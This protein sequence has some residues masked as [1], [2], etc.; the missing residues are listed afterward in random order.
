MTR[1][2]L[3]EE[4]R[5]AKGNNLVIAHQHF[6]NS[7]L[8]G[9]DLSFVTFENCI[10]AEI[11]FYKTRSKPSTFMN[12]VFIYCDFKGSKMPMSQWSEYDNCEFDIQYSAAYKNISLLNGKAQVK[13]DPPVENHECI[14][15]LEM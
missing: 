1:E 5:K 3:L 6:H 14:F 10:F 2:E 4:I 7:N 12:C 13:I 9:L 8:R 15:T 11:E